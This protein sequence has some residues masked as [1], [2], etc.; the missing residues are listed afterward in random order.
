MNNQYTEPR[1]VTTQELAERLKVSVN[2]VL[3]NVKA[4]VWPH[5]Q[6]LG[7]RPYKFDLDEVMSLLSEDRSLTIKSRDKSKLSKDLRP[8][9]KG[10][11]A[12]RLWPK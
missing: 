8:S 3:L 9:Q 4:G 6:A 7:T 2:L 5:L 11:S 12:K 1:I 10:R